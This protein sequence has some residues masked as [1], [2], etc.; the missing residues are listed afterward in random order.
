MV[1]LTFDLDLDLDMINI[2]HY[3]KFEP[4]KSNGS[5]HIN[6]YLVIFGPIRQTMVSVTDVWYACDGI[7]DLNME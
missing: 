3:T 2:Y 4:P 5:R 7:V 1:S 6:F